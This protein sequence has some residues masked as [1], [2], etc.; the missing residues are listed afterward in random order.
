MRIRQVSYPYLNGGQWP[1]LRGLRTEVL[2]TVPES[3]TVTRLLMFIGMTVGGYIG[4]AAGD[5]MGFGLM[6]KFMVS[7]VGSFAGI[8]AAWRVLT[9]YLE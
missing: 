2:H 8:Y 5:Y 1:T 9:D 7:S 4:W 6:G 3:H